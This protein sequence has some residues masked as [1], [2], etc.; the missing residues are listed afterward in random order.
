[1]TKREA[2]QICYDMWSWLAANPQASR[3]DW[4]RSH[5]EIAPMTSGCS[6]CEYVHQ[7]QEDTFDC[8]RC[9]I[10]DFWKAG[11]ADKWTLNIC[12]NKEQFHDYCV[13][14]VYGEWL[15]NHHNDERRTHYAQLIANAAKKELENLS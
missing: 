2:L 9:P 6:C 7:Q 14:S 1:M 11:I 10:V 3:D 5:P 12:S 8:N 15:D 13:S 4:L